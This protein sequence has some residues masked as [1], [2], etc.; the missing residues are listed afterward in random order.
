VFVE[1]DGLLLLID[2][3]D[4]N[5]P[6]QPVDVRFNMAGDAFIVSDTRGQVTMFQTQANRYM[7]VCQDKRH[8]NV[9]WATFT[10]RAPHDQVLVVLKERK[11]I[12]THSLNGKLIDKFQNTHNT[13]IRGL[14][15]NMVMMGHI[16]TV[17]ADACNI[18]STSGAGTNSVSKLRSVY[19]KDGNHFVQARFTADGH[20]LVTL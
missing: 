17:S 18:W 6:N 3:K 15:H 5:K 10:S 13:E 9:Q 12:E 16:A 4:K 20:S 1:Q 11:T 8:G 2:L 7:V 19:S 14:E